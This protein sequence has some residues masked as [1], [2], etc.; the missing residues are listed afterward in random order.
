MRRRHPVSWPRE[1]A[2]SPGVALICP[3]QRGAAVGLVARIR[4]RQE[5]SGGD[6]K[7]RVGCYLN[8]K[9]IFRNRCSLSRRLYYVTRF[10]QGSSISAVDAGGGGTARAAQ[11]QRTTTGSSAGGGEV[12]VFS[13][14]GAGEKRG[15]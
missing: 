10:S 7:K 5:K 3:G 4:R 11:R 9:A 2:P 13:G 1:R 15:G 8:A 12:G 6:A 14:R